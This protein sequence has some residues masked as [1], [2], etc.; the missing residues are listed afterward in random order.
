MKT[1]KFKA[2]MILVGLLLVN[3]QTISAGI[4]DD[5]K[6]TAGNE[7]SNFNMQGLLIIGGIIGAGLVIY[8]ISNYFMKEKEEYVD[9]KQSSHIAKHNH[10][11]Y[12]QRHYPNRHI[13]KKTS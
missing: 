8:I 10:D 5:V 6:K 9:A 4:I 3:V 2:F 1:T 13:V 11:R 12:Q 7:I